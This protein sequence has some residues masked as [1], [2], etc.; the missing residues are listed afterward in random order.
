MVTILNAWQEK[1]RK[2]KV[3]HIDKLTFVVC[4]VQVATST[5][6]YVQVAIHGLVA[7]SR[8]AIH[9]ASHPTIG[10]PG[11]HRTAV[12]TGTTGITDTPGTTG[13]PASPCTHVATSG[14]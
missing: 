3:K 14:A 7:T 9:I 5:C 6:V 10:K 11:K 2:Q 8:L 4:T 13:T 1:E 12:T